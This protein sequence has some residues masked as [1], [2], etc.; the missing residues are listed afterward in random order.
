[1]AN[2]QEADRPPIAALFVSY[3]DTRAGYTLGWHR[4]IS[5][6]ELE[7]VVE[8]KA[9][10]SGLHNVQEDLVYFIHDRHAGVS[11][12]VSRAAGEEDRHAVM[13][14]VGILAPLSYGRL[15]R[16]WLHAEAL[17]DMAQHLARRMVEDKSLVDATSR[18]ESL[19]HYWNTFQ[20]NE[21][22]DES[23]TRSP[24][25]SS[26]SLKYQSPPSMK[27]KNV[28]EHMR[29]R[30]VS[31]GIAVMN[32]NPSLS[33]F[34]PAESLS[35][36]VDVFGPLIFPLQRAALLRKRILILCEAPVQQP[37]YFVLSN[38]PLLIQDVLSSS[39]PST[40]LRP[41]FT[42]TIHD[43]PLL[44]KEAEA[45]SDHGP[46]DDGLDAG[47]TDYGSGWV[48]CTTDGVLATKDRLY[49]VI[50][51]LPPHHSQNKGDSGWPRIESPRGTVIKATQR[52]AR[53][54]Q[55]LRRALGSASQFDT[56]LTDDMTRD[57]E[58]ARL[59]PERQE[60]ISGGDTDNHSVDETVVEPMSWPALVYSS[61]MW[62]ASA[63]EKRSDLDEEK[64]VDLTLLSGLLDDHETES[65]DDEGDEEGGGDT[66]QTRR[67]KAMSQ[68]AIIAYFHRLSSL[69][70]T[71]LADIVQSA[72][73]EEEGEEGQ[74]EEEVFVSS[75]DMG[76]MCLDI[77]SAND[78]AFVEELILSYF[79]RR[80]R[81]QGGSVECC[82][83]RI[84]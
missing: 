63:G 26:A 16:S 13:M 27:L 45:L 11:A 4:A 75:E 33:P 78:R 84:G 68:M 79:G 76:R 28:D 9:L 12:F 19:E 20:M 32:A 59:L 80:A 77:W 52:D 41:L 57:D 48:A 69:V 2:A 47:P 49:D 31:D 74:D 82:G 23:R 62:W 44:E 14:A 66:A 39:A 51:T 22:D 40:R 55:E 70:L 8:Y 37:C 7:G 65:P 81:V 38:V 3:F 72:E 29:S 1:M 61:M 35:Q 24:D 34:H 46:D 18:Q 10:P 5:G 25:E 60:D 67:S 30:S 64:E 73:A 54:Y 15:G 58:E 6:V 21:D 71:T 36:F 17:K 83:V 43:I 53:R 42:V 50:I 56:S